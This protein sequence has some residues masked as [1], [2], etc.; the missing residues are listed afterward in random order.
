VL[1][2]IDEKVSGREITKPTAT[3]PPHQVIDLMQA[4][5]ESMKR[6]SARAAA[7]RKRPARKASS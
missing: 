3:P 6:A 2:L 1:A 4:L 5:K 7:E